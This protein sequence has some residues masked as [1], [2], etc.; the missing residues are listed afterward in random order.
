M[1]GECARTDGTRCRYIVIVLLADRLCTASDEMCTFRLTSDALE[2]RWGYAITIHK[3]MWAAH[4]L[5]MHNNG[6]DK[7]DETK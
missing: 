4:P 1:C 2:R 7:K 5:R 6:V 3:F